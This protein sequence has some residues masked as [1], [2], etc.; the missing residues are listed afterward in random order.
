MGCCGAGVPDGDGSGPG[1]SGPSD[2]DGSPGSGAGSV[3]GASGTGGPVGACA[4]AA[5][6]R[7]GREPDVVPAPPGAELERIAVAGT[8]DGP[9]TGAGGSADALTGGPG[10][11]SVVVVAYSRT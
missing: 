3:E 2:G 4:G 10:A 9:S 5:L 11:G 7:P 1:S 6:V 8:E